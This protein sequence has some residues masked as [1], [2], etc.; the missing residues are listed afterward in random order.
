MAARN[1]NGIEVLNP[2]EAGG[3]TGSVTFPLTGR[4]DSVDVMRGLTILA[5]AF[6]NDLADFAPVKGVPQWLRHMKAGANGFTFVDMIIPIFMFILGMSVPLALGKRLAREGGSP[7]RVLGHV[8][9]RGVSLIIIGLMDANRGAGLGRPYGDMLD[10]PHGLWKFLA[11]TFVFIVWLDI[12]L[13]SARAKSVHK[14]IRIAG[15]AGL[16]WLAVVFRNASGGHFV[17]AKWSTLGQLGWA[18]LFASLTWFIFRNRRSGIIGV[19]VL[20]HCLFIGI[21]GGLFQDVW[22]VNWIGASILGTYSANAVAGL[23][24]G[25]LLMERSGPKEKIRGALG[26]A[27]FTGMAAFL[28]QPVG[29]LHLPSTSWSLYST[30]CAFAAWALFYWSID[31]KGWKKGWGPV[32]TVGQNCLFLYQMSRYWIF[33]YWLSGLTFYEALGADTA[34]GIVRAVV[35]TAFLGTITVMATKK[36]VFLRV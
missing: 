30:S 36:K 9:T 2:A 7:V 3:G 5:M 35:Y 14:L 27:V 10:W 26:L 25:V 17:I 6:V 31:V 28:L 4:V 34:T 1:L 32:R 13:K 20:F 22:L 19:F 12:P 23:I 18:Y 29:G 8:L 21:K 33:I 11:W 24:I 16:V 15:L